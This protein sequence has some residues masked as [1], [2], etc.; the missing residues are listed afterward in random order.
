[1]TSELISVSISLASGILGTWIK[2]N[3]DLTKMK[4]RVDM[5]ERNEAKVEVALRELIDGINEIKLLLAKN[6]VE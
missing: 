5:L 3:N 2:L 6:R 1:M 4:S